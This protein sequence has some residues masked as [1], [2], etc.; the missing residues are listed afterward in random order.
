MVVCRFGNDI[1]SA[2]RELK[3][4]I[5]GHQCRIFRPINNRFQ[6]MLHTQSFAMPL[7]RGSTT[8]LTAKRF[9]YT[10]PPVLFCSLPGGKPTSKAGNRS[11][12]T[13]PHQTGSKML[14]SVFIPAELVF[15]TS[16]RLSMASL[17]EVFWGHSEGGI[18]ISVPGIDSLVSDASNIRYALL[19]PVLCFVYIVWYS[20]SGHKQAFDA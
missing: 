17:L 11:G 14:N 18:A 19:L 7:L 15:R 13:I 8:V 5:A 3:P 12:S 1:L 2:I 20:S 4:A 9:L 16:L 10:T 6:L